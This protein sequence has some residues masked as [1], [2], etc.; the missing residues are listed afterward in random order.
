MADY[1][2]KSYRKRIYRFLKNYE[3]EPVVITGVPPYMLQKILF[4]NCNEGEHVF[5]SKISEVIEKI[6]FRNVNFDR[7]H[8]EGMDFSKLKNVKLNPDTIDLS[9]TRNKVIFDGV[10]FT[11]EIIVYLS[12]E[13]QNKIFKGS[14]NAEIKLEKSSKNTFLD[15]IFFSNDDFCDVTFKNPLN[16]QI[17]F[18]GCSFEGSHGAIIDLGKVDF[19]DTILYDATIFGKLDSFKHREITPSVE[20]IKRM[21][22][23]VT[24]PTLIRRK[25]F[26]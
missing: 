10:Y 8:I 17:A 22:G 15:W 11:K 23:D 13:I 2:I 4:K 24:E 26:N 5:S 9:G 19:W 1:I 21:Y 14:H 6:D 25:D 7:F 16:S 3:G 20:E 18:F 12:T